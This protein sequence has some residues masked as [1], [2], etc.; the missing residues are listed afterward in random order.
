MG[1]NE[2]AGRTHVDEAWPK[3]VRGLKLADQTRRVRAVC[4]GHLKIHLEFV[5]QCSKCCEVGGKD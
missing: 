3:P 5:H 1:L 4:D 2:P